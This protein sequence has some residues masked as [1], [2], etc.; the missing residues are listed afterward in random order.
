V[1][2]GNAALVKNIR[3]IVHSAA[4]YLVFCHSKIPDHL[5][6]IPGHS[7]TLSKHLSIV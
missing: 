4:I 1:F 5:S 7:V 6:E 3:E 2:L